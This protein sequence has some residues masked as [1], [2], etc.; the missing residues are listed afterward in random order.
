MNP[1]M[2]WLQAK[3]ADTQ[4]MMLFVSLLAI[5][6][7]LSLFGD[8]LAPL[9]VAIAL[10]YVMESGID[11]LER[12]KL[13]RFI[14]IG[15]VGSGALL[16]VLFALFTLLPL[17]SGQLGRLIGQVPEYVKSTRGFLETL[18]HDYSGWLNPDYL[19]QLVATLASKLQG[20]GAD[21][22]SFSLSSIPGVITLLVYVVLVPVLV[23]FLLKDKQ[24]LMNWGKGLLPSDH[25][26]LNR[27]WKEVDIQIGNYIRGKFIE[28]LIVGVAM[29]VAYV[30]LGHEYALLLAVL[31]G[32][33]VWV[34][35]IGAAVVTV[36]VVLLS[37]FQWGWSDATLYSLIIY[38]VIQTLDANVVIP[39]LFSEVVN[40]HPIAIIMAVL[41]F[42][43]LWGL[44][45]VFVAIPM[46]S[47]VKSVLTIVA[48]RK[49]M[50]SEA[51]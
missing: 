24:L 42:G 31:T 40:L 29:W 1:V 15:I 18:Q 11:F 45:G 25:L 35:F 8:V 38:A 30:V 28:T 33:S 4:L 9:L 39:W 51:G 50:I 14:G 27:V 34:P 13:P 2:R 47:L 3:L 20:W 44:V 41:V 5:F 46:A 10:A 22:L 36:P 19:Q 23:F 43:S 21:L 37:L 12:C 7:L 6:V 17:L 49:D 16:M 32:V 48:E 26:L